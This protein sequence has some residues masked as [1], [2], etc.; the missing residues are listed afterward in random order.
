MWYY[1]VP[2][3]RLR[4]GKTLAKTL[5]GEPLLLGRAQDGRVFAL[6]NICPHRG[7]P[8]SY[9]HFDGHEIECCYHGWRFTPSGACTAIPSLAADQRLDLATV[10]VASYPAREEG[11][12]VWVFFGEDA[13]S[14][15]PPPALPSGFDARNPDIY[16]TVTLPC[17]IDHAVVGLMD[18]AAWAFRP[19]LLVVAQRTL[20]PRKEQGLRREPLRLHHAAARAVEQFQSL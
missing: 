5:L 8:L 1:A 2:G 18:P 6:R 20:D 12:N 7:I 16:E 17:G 19:S 15:P 9:G 13:A 14:A 4:R 3:E 10:S 11:G